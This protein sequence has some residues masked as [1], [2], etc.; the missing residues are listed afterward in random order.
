MARTRTLIQIGGLAHKAGLLD[1]LGVFV[2]L[3]LQLGGAEAAKSAAMLLGA[4]ASLAEQLKGP[5]GEQLREGWQSRG[6][7]L[8]RH[9]ED[10]EASEEFDL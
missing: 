8:F 3:D 5:A 10:S 4:F 7:L 1:A 6:S 2:G 9:D